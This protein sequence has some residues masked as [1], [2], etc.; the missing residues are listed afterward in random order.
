MSFFPYHLH[1]NGLQVSSEHNSQSTKCWLMTL[2]LHPL[3]F[4]L[5]CRFMGIQTDTGK[6]W[7]SSCHGDWWQKRKASLSSFPCDH[8]S[9]L[10]IGSSRKATTKGLGL[11]GSSL[12]SPWSFT[13]NQL[14]CVSCY[15]H[16]S[17]FLWK[18]KWW[19]NKYL[20]SAYR[21]FQTWVE[22]RVYNSLFKESISLFIYLAGD[23][24]SAWQRLRYIAETRNFYKRW[25]R[26]HNWN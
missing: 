1:S 12:S 25:R 20:L 18:N 15:K 6:G 24:N 23:A 5:W 22:L 17:T 9:P 4:L 13:E 14:V 16:V 2:T 3:S 11:E 19:I 7:L 21:A 8:T 26:R 10:D